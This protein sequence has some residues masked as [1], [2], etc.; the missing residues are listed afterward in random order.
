MYL[1]NLIFVSPVIV[2]NWCCNLKRSN[3]FANY[4]A[5][6]KDWHD[7][8]TF[9]CT[10]WIHTSTSILIS[11]Y[12]TGDH[13]GNPNQIM[14]IFIDQKHCFQKLNN[15]LSWDLKFCSPRFFVLIPNEFCPYW[16]SSLSVIRFPKTMFVS[17]PVITTSAQ[18]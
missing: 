1:F 14:V 9:I 10:L 12:A 17:S 5:T 2:H 15:R 4:S 6:T 18:N 3:I 13:S 8:W 16:S 11:V 7:Y